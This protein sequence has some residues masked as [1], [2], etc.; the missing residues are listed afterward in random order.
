MAADLT[1]ET[2]IRIIGPDLLPDRAGQV[3]RDGL[4]QPGMRV[5]GD[6]AHPAQAAGDEVSKER[7]P[8]RGGLARRDPQAKHLTAT[9]GVHPGS[10]QHDGVD[11]AAALADLH[12]QRVGG[13]ERERASV[14]ERAVAE[15]LN[16]L[17]ELRGPRSTP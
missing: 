3:R 15:L 16:V 8:R 17:V 10:N 7:F 9:V 13:D 2:L 6:E 11:D 1:V 14:A 4:D 12:R 5:A